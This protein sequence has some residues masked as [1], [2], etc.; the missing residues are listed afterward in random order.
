MKAFIAMKPALSSMLLVA[1]LLLQQS[2]NDS[3]MEPAMGEASL[4]FKAETTHSTLA[5][6][7]VMATGLEYNTILLGLTKLE[8][9][10]EG[11]QGDDDD[12]HEGEDADS[13]D[14]DEHEEEIEF[15]GAYVVDL[16][17]GMSTPDFGMATLSPGNY[18]EIEVEFGPVLPD[19][20]TVFIELDYV[21]EG[22]VM[23][24]TVQYSN[25]YTLELEL[26]NTRGIDVM[27]DGYTQLLMVLDLDAVFDPV[28]LSAATADEDGIVRINANSNAA[29]ASA[30]EAN[31]SDAFKCGEDHDDDGEIDED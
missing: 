1:L 25:R 3:D 29:I 27:A 19:G 23:P 5:N 10:L 26:E 30:I 2:C 20:N 8:L 28:D 22:G 18:D 11:E 21:P 6:A 17:N 16:I 24:V 31:F 14:R 13:L 9:E 4:T 7:R 12:D 15:E